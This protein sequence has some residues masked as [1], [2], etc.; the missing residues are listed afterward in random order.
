MLFSFDARYI[1]LSSQFE[2]KWMRRNK[3]INRV[4]DFPEMDWRSALGKK[5][6]EILSHYL[7]EMKRELSNKC[8]YKHG[9]KLLESNKW[10]DTDFS[11]VI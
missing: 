10:F 6:H 2:K 9:L 3:D 8:R 7:R 5:R 1:K 11:N 4:D